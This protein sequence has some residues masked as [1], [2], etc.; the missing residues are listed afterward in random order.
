MQS[1][2]RRIQYPE[3]NGPCLAKWKGCLN[4]VEQR[5]DMELIS[6]RR[7]VVLLAFTAT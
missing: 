5:L 7:G 6:N 2:T 3:G 1:T 4:V